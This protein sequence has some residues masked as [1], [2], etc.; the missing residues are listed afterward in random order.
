MYLKIVCL[1]FIG[2]ISEQPVTNFGDIHELKLKTQWIMD[3]VVIDF[4][5]VGTDSR[6]P[7]GVMCVQA[8]EV[9]ADICISASGKK[10]TLKV[11]ITP[12]TIQPMVLFK[13]NDMT[14]Y[15]KA[16][17]PYPLPDTQI[18]DSDYR[19]I[20]KIFKNQ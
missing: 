12:T 9:I 2:F 19:L 18:N 7:K 4:V 20:L 17:A 15:A 8:G 1:L 13:S 10:K 14:I 5:S 6:C 11:T 3:D 16:L